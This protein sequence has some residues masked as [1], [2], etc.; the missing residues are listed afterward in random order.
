MRWGLFFCVMASAAAA[1]PP[2]PTLGSPSD[3]GWAPRDPDLIALVP[4][5]SPEAVATEFEVYDL[6]GGLVTARALPRDFTNTTQTL[7]LSPLPDAGFFT[8]RARTADDAGVRSAWSGEGAFKVD[9]IPPTTPATLTVELD[10]GALRLI[11]SLITDGESGLDVHHFIISMLDQQDGGISAPGR[12]GMTSASPLR[13]TRLGPG[14]WFVGVH[15]H[16]FVMNVGGTTIVGPLV[17]PASAVVPA[18]ETPQVV[19]GDGGVFATDPFVPF[20]RVRLRVDAGTFVP[21]GFVAVRRAVGATQWEPAAVATTNPFS[22]SLDDGDQEVRVSMHVGTEVSGWSAPRRIYV[23]DTAPGMPA[24]SVARDGGAVLL[25]W[26]PTRDDLP[27]GSGVVDYRVTRWASLDAGTAL[28]TVTNV[29]DASVLVSSDTLP[30]LGV[31]RY[32]VAAVDRAGNAGAPGI[33]VVTWAPDP[34]IGLQVARLVTNQPVQLSWTDPGAVTWDVLRIDAAD[35]GVGVASGLNVP[36][37]D[38]AA[39]EGAWSYEVRAR[40]NGAVSGP[41]RLDGVVVDLTLPSVTTPAVL[42][43]GSRAAEVSWTASDGLS[44]LA[45][46]VLER[47]TDGVVTPVAGAV[48]PLADQPADG[49]HRYRVVASDVAGNVATSAWSAVF[50]T[51]GAGVQ[52][53]RPGPLEATCGRELVLAL[54]ASEAVTWS[55]SP[56]ASVDETSGVLS[57]TP[58]A[59]EVGVVSLVVSAR[60]ATSSDSIE[61]PVQVS[62]TPERYSLGCGCDSGGGV[63][64]L[65][66]VWMLRRKK[67]PSPR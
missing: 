4:V 42:R 60:A 26:P 12:L 37:F 10:G 57:W 28:P 16:D 25:R 56:P 23:D 22:V 51:P 33:A 36:L 5:S 46:V 3:G 2:V 43:T 20:A 27:V 63:L 14:S 34:P 65:A 49:T 53:V 64:L 6:D 30:G 54:N 11:S 29:P 24:V 32:S 61:V 66:G 38:D 19:R 21:T 17:V 39:G 40:V 50:V 41:A 58:S 45:S 13:D 7:A 8:W 47:E 9:A 18:P 67:L 55:V 48:S 1:L 15:G 35:A 52:I 62:C 31:W 59:E 44:G